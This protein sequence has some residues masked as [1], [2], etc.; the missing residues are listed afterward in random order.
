M[1]LLVSKNDIVEVFCKFKGHIVPSTD[2]QQL[3]SNPND[4]VTSTCE[5]CNFSILIRADPDDPNYY[6]VSDHE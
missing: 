4:E 2:I 1:A 3:K 6:L 5:R